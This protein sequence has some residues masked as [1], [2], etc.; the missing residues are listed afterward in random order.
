MLFLKDVPLSHTE[1]GSVHQAIL[2]RSSTDQQLWQQI[3]REFSFLFLCN[4]NVVSLKTFQVLQNNII[5]VMKEIY[6]GFFLSICCFYTII[7]IGKPIRF[8]TELF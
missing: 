2:Y 7:D 3:S 8:E 6:K 4:C 5:P 1:H